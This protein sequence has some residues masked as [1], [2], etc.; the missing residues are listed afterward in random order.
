MKHIVDLIRYKHLNNGFDFNP[1][2]TLFDE[3]EFERPRVC[4]EFG[5]RM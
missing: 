1:P 3:N 5:L 4:F 2:V